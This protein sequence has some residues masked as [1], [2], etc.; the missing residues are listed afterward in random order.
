[1]CVVLRG[2]SS[3]IYS[4]RPMLVATRPSRHVAGIR[5][6]IQTPF[7]SK[8][9]QS[10][11][12]ARY[13]A[14]VPNAYAMPRHVVTSLYGP[15]LIAFVFSAVMLSVCVCVC[16]CVLVC[17]RKRRLWLR[18]VAH[19]RRRAAD[20]HARLQ[21]IDQVADGCDEDEEDEN[22]EEDDDVALHGGGLLGSLV[23]V[24][25]RGDVREDVIRCW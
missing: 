20:C 10:L 6:I 5:S 17:W 8:L 3:T 24:V 4:T 25:E 21:V 15:H 14:H 22:D 18:H 19:A 23:V 16:V 1:M 11:P 2:P 9:Q 13:V 7:F 12:E